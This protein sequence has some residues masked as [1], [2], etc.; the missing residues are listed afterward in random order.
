MTGLGQTM[1]GVSRYLYSVIAAEEGSA[2]E[3]SRIDPLTFELISLCS[4]RAVQG[5]RVSSLASETSR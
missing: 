1:T 2:D 4:G 5:L 3:F